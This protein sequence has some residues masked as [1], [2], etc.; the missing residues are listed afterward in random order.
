MKTCP[1]CGRQYAD[2]VTV[3]PS[4]GEPLGAV[5]VAGARATGDV[6]DETLVRPKRA[7]PIAAPR[8]TE[9]R[10]GATANPP[11]PGDVR[12]TETPDRVYRERSPWPAISAVG[13][14]VA[15]GVVA[16]IYFVMA[17][18]KD[19]DKEVGAQITDA[20]VSVAD[21]RA[22]LE[23]LPMDAPLRN[24][25]LTLQQW[26]RELQNLEVGHERTREVAARARE[27]GSQ[28][29][30]IGEEARVAGATVPATPPVVQ[31]AA[32]Q[33]TAPVVDPAVDPMASTPTVET[34]PEA[35]P[36]APPTV[37]PSTSAP[38]Q[39]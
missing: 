34:P 25:L 21:A 23:S 9:V 3:C 5:T 11:P 20:R 13:A 1:V 33:P 26:D 32:P 16:A 7:Q 14:L 6:D 2:D 4:D 24:R 31:P 22:R 39:P 15:V 27:I 29:R 10:I 8:F 37:T 18:Q 38:P 19:F 30:T 17:G 36:A 35:K 28:A 12:R